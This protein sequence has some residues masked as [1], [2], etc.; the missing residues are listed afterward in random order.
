M[1]SALSTQGKVWYFAYGSN[2]SVDVMKKRV[3]Q[4]QLSKRALARNYRLVFN[5]LSEKQWKGY[6][7]NLEETG[8]FEDTV[9]GVVYRI[10][11]EQLNTLERIEGTRPLEIRVELEDGNEISHART[12]LWKSTEKEKEPPK[13]YKRVMEE[14]LVQH[15]YGEDRARKIFERFSVDEGRKKST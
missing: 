1:S 3:G 15:G 2:L 11:P 8:N 9:P 12:F 7:A 10:S 5:H 13:E 4:W 14:G 6:V